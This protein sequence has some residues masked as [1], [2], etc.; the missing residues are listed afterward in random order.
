MARPRSS[1]AVGGGRTMLEL[2]LTPESP[3]GGAMARLSHDAVRSLASKTG[4]SAPVVSLYLDV[5]GRRYVRPKDYESEL[6]R[7]LRQARER[8][9]GSR[10]TAGQEVARSD[11]RVRCG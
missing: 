1:H 9:H 11:A 4:G 8:A 6:D 2:R 10:A 5:D 3:P 7:M